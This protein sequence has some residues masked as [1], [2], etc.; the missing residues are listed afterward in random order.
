MS[1]KAEALVV[2]WVLDERDHLMR[3]TARGWTK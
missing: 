2:I 3:S 1:D